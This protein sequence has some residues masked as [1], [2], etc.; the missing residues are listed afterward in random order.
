MHRRRKDQE[1]YTRREPSKRISLFSSPLFFLPPSDTLLPSTGLV[2]LFPRRKWG[3]NRG[4]VEDVSEE[5]KERN[6]QK[7]EKKRKKEKMEEMSNP[8]VLSVEEKR[9][10]V[11]SFFTKNF[12]VSRRKEKVPAN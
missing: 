8:R 2:N 3:E 9:R 12:F 6:I 7:K 1:L 11:G 5:K 4:T 10:N